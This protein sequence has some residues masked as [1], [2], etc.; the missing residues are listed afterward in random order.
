MAGFQLIAEPESVRREQ[1]SS[2]GPRHACAACKSALPRN[3]VKPPRA[4]SSRARSRP[5]LAAPALA[6]GREISAAAAEQDIEKPRRRAVGELRR[7]AF[8]VA[9]VGKVRVKGSRDGSVRLPLV[10]RPRAR[11]GRGREF[12]EV[13]RRLPAGSRARTRGVELHAAGQRPGGGGGIGTAKSAACVVSSARLGSDAMASRRSAP[14][15]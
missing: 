14:P 3:A 1:P 15:S 2:R 10:T 7:D 11:P 13:G 6:V 8:A 4:G 9:R 12:G 5:S